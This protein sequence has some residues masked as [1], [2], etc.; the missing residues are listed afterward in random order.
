VAASKTTPNRSKR[1]KTVGLV[2]AFA[3]AA[4]VGG[5]SGAGVTALVINNSQS[6]QAS[7]SSAV[8]PANITVN[9]PDNATTITKVAA[10]ATPSV[11]TINTTG[12]TAAGTGSGVILSSDGYILTNT[13][14]VTLDGEVANAKVSVQTSDGHIYSA[15][16]IGTDPISDLAVVKIDATGLQPITFADSS[17]LN[18]GDTAIAIG[19]PLALSNTV[20]NG[21]VSALNRSI[22]IASSAVPPSTSSSDG[23][24]TAPNGGGNGSG[25]DPFGFQFPQGGGGGQQQA[26]PQPTAQASIALS[27][28]QTDAAINP[29]NSGG[30]LLNANGQVMG[31]NV[32]IA[33]ASSS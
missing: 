22:T 30:A 14:V 23:G 27:V 11:V 32:A 18:V 5:V 31:I 15:K 25:S 9:N 7:A 29:G 4:L 12:T 20:T 19:A 2:A 3:V 8:N 10:E 33:S 1:G 13:H 26:Q 24:N 16:I 28:I 17:K 21:I 6:S